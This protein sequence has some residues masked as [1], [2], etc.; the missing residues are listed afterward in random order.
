MAS[1]RP[2][3]ADTQIEIL[4]ESAAS[5]TSTDEISIRAPR[6]RVLAIIGLVGL[7]TAITWTLWTPPAGRPGNEPTTTA[8]ASQSA[9]VVGSSVFVPWPDPPEDHDPHVIGRPGP[10]RTVVPGIQRGAVIYVNSLGR[11]TVVRLDDGAVDEVEV[12]SVRDYDSF[13]ISDG[14]VLATGSAQIPDLNAIDPVLVHLH[15][16]LS[17]VPVGPSPVP[18]PGPHLCLD[19]EHCNHLGWIPRSLV[20]DSAVLERLDSQK[21]P[22]IASIF[23]SGL[24]IRNGR[25]L[26]APESA[27]LGKYRIPA[28]LN[29]DIWVLSQAP[30]DSQ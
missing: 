6:R 12:S 7:I 26:E 17:L 21:W 15:R 2:D 27:E 10:G 25:W 18:E 4:Q 24:W 28:P 3:S 5:S 11:A 29:S 30:S 13:W 14:R 19:D 23:N 1:T 9:P 20:S 8:A 22:E 16:S